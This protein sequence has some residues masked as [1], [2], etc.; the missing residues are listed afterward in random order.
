MNFQEVMLALSRFWADRGCMVWQPYNVQV[1]AGTMNPATFLRVLGPE[2]WNVAYVEPSIRPTD[3]RYGENPNRLQQ[4]YQYQVILKPAPAD[5]QET[6]LESLNALGIDPYRHDVRFVEDNWES[7]AL[8]A[9]GLGWEVWLDGL[10]ITQ[11]TYFQQAGGF[12]LDPVS[13]EITYGLERIVMYL[14]DAQSVYDIDWGAGLS[15]GDILLQGEIEHCRYNFEQA[16]VE[17]LVRLYNEYEGEA[18][19]ALESGLVFPAYDYILKCSHTFNVLDARGAI[20]VTERASYFARMRTMARSVAEAYLDQRERLEHPFTKLAVPSSLPQGAPSPGAG[21]EKAIEAPPSPEITPQETEELASQA[22]L[23]LEIGTEELPPGDV[24]SALEQ[25][26]EA[27]PRKLKDLRLSHQGIRVLGTPRRLAVLVAGLARRQDDREETVKGPPLR[28]AFDE[29]GK[30]TQAAEGFAKKLGISTDDLQSQDFDGRE[31]VVGMHVERGREA[32]DVL[33]EAVPEMISSL[34]FD[35]TMRWNDSGVAFARPIRWIVAL[36]GSQVVEFVFDGVPS[37]RVSRGLRPHGS[38]EIPL[39]SAGHY[40]QALR[41]NMIMVDPD[42]RRE[43]VRSQMRELAEKIGGEIPHDPALLDEVTHM[44]EAPTAVMGSFQDKYLEL[45]RDVLITVMKKHQRY[46]PVIRDGELL[47]RFV[48]IRNGGTEDLDVVRHGY[49]EVLRAR[50]SDAAFFFRSDLEQGLEDFLPSLSGLTFQEELGSVRDKV[51]RLERLIPIIGGLLDLDAQ[52]LEVAQRAG[53]LCKADL[54]TDMV[55]EFTSLQ[56]IMGREYARLC[57]EDE[58][59]SQAI[60]EHYLPRFAGEAVALSPAGIAVGL[61]D[62]LDSLAGLFAVG[63]APTGSA[64]P[65]GLRRTALGLVQILIGRSISFDVDKAL[66]E[67]A[68]LLPVTPG[69]ERIEQTVDFVK[70]RLRG[71]LLERG[72]RHDVVDSILAERGND[73]FTATN[74]VQEL[75]GWV[76]KPEWPDILAAYSRS[77]RIVR[78]YS[79][80]FP[81][82]PDG[83]IESAEGELYKAYLEARQQVKPDSSVDSFLEVI[84]SMVEPITVFFDEVLVMD[85]DPAL[86]QNRLALVQRIASLSRGIADLSLLMG[87]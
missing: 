86:Q 55:I 31:Y 56:G 52:D 80:E 14:Q 34:H 11:F 83:F 2:P 4:F 20:G 72:Y 29:A 57:G 73:P 65:Y 42:E 47:P 74:S 78:E 25:L 24:T 40:L 21:D 50:Y 68:K 17:R 77:K 15:Y 75:T 87:F 13:V 63:L 36:L 85:P 30:A 54:A 10:E 44:V 46:F 49:Q 69:E 6:Y 64:D 67:A 18:R 79:Q 59:V 27:A 12:D 41:T 33:A 51:S 3:G 9:W 19:L 22:D 23:V 38:Q 26:K 28:A 62:R 43:A 81:L 37:G 48:A 60:H 70:G 5:P 1:G 8:G 66:R 58:A 53:Y 45:P 7:P 61:S 84:R 32:A 82:D 16:D 35:L 71:L 39:A 76:E